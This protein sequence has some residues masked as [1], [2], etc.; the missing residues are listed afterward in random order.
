M[1]KPFLNIHPDILKLG[2][3]SFLTDVSSEAIFSVFAL[4]FT[5]FAGAS[6]ALLGLIEGMADFAA[7]SLDYLSGWLADRLGERKSLTIV[8]YG[9]STLAKLSL[10]FVN[11]IAAL[12][13]FRIVE[14][15]GKSFRGPPRD[16]WIAEM[17]DAGIRGYSFGV[18]K[19]L[20]KSGAILGPLFAYYLLDKYGESLSTFR[21]IFITASV[22]AILAI[23]ALMAIKDRPGKSHERDNMFKAY[24]K[25]S[26]KFKSFL[27]PA[28]LFSLA[29]F[30]FGF[31]LLRAYAAGFTVKNVVLLYAL[32]NIAFVV[33]S[34]LVGLLGDT[35]GRR[36]I[37]LLGYVV[38]MIMSAGFIFAVEGWQIILLFV[39]LGVFYS[40][41]EGQ[42]KAFI[43]DL[44]GERRAT[45]I[46]IYNFFNG[47]IYLPASVIAGSLWL[48]NP[49]YAFL[50]AI[51]MS[52]LAVTT[53]LI[54]V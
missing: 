16:A 26:P 33:A 7:S 47:L 52:A 21:I 53:F 43:A 4:F 32:F 51:V 12:G 35:I 1:K 3:V 28:G 10:V 45:A 19:A 17:A 23:F 49:S 54:Y 44:E 37:I 6:S 22:S 8:G 48:V 13:L 15:L 11:T 5:I 40:I 38:Y 20:D 46:G 36:Y 2:I 39:I 41:D 42:S 29:Y 18:H 30:S 24:S 25:L 27:L 31:L 14:R 50:F 34:P 9:F